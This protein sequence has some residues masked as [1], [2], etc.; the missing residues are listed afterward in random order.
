MDK[1]KLNKN[2]KNNDGDDVAAAAVGA[3]YDGNNSD[4]H[5]NIESSSEAMIVLNSQ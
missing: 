3:G 2:N 5:P 1:N 4:S